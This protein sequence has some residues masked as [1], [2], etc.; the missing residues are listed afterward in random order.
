MHLPMRRQTM[1]PSRRSS[2]RPSILNPSI[3]NTDEPKRRD[4]KIVRDK[5]YQS[6]CYEKVYSFLN[7]KGYDGNLNNKTLLSPSVKD[8]QNIFKFIVEFINPNYE[9]GRI[10]EDVLTIIKAIKYP[11]INEI[12]RSQ[13]IAITPHTWPVILSMLAWLVDFI[14][15]V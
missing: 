12:T 14:Q 5:E 15:T 7:E 1:T 6:Q 8:F 3:K 4:V 9:Y 2:V 11:Y 13:L 10:E